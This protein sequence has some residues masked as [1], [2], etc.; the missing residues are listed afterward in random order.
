MG[1]GAIFG[2]V[3]WSDGA[4]SAITRQLELHV[5]A[6]HPLEES[7]GMSDKDKVSVDKTS[8]A[9]KEI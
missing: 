4:I 5:K 3:P 2:P 8:Q 6:E 9:Y 7:H 1:C